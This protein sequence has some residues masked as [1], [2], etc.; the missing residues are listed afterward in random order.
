MHP[1]LT[2]EQRF[3]SKVD[4]SG[5]PDACWLWTAH[6]HK[7]YGRFGVGS[8]VQAA[9][10]ISWELTNGPI[11]RGMHVLHDCPGGDNPACCN[12]AHLR[13]GTH[14]D[15]MADMS[16]KGRRAPILV[17]RGELHG[18]AKLTD[19]QVAEI[20]RRYAAGGISQPN[21]AKE[22]G[23]SQSHICRLVLQQNR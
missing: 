23:V 17:R 7:G 5:G 19:A 21:L 18:Q 4:R 10:R 2:L 3:W 22:F 15:N 13:I 1:K 11:P 12:P 8:T 20:R 16:A 14:I 6:R 9:H